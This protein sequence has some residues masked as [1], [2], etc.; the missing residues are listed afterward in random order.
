[1]TDRKSNEDIEEELR[2]VSI[3]WRMRVNRIL[4]VLYQYKPNGRCHGRPTKM[5]ETVLILGQEPDTVHDDEQE[6]YLC[7]KLFLLISISRSTKLVF[8]MRFLF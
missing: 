6:T 4:E 1:M 8:S 3:L 7:M 5:E 2:M